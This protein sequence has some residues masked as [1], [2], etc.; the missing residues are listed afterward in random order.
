MKTYTEEEVLLL[1]E[2][3]HIAGQFYED[4]TIVKAGKGNQFKRVN[5]DKR[6]QRHSFKNWAKRNSLIK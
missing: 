4:N 2:N 6:N 5:L 3:A 1:C